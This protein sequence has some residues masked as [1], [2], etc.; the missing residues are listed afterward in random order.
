M[1]IQELD[2]LSSEIYS[3]TFFSSR[4][5]VTDLCE[6]VLRLRRFVWVC[7]FRPVRRAL[8]L[9][10]RKKSV[11]PSKIRQKSPRPI[12]ATPVLS[13]EKKRTSFAQDF[14][15]IAQ[16]FTVA[17]RPPDT[18]YLSMYRKRSTGAV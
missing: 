12:S 13:V 5:P 6:W 17:S 9:L 15:Y 16:I 1:S 7:F 8:V 4:A 18:K 11:W 2:I 3:H 14:C 10:C